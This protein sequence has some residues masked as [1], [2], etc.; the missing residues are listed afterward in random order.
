MWKKMSILSLF[1]TFCTHFFE[2]KC[3]WEFGLRRKG[4]KTDTSSNH[5]HLPVPPQKSLVQN[6]IHL[7]PK[8]LTDKILPFP[9]ANT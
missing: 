6:N 3:I 8:F 5:L 7:Y 9:W 4:V 1:E 2:K